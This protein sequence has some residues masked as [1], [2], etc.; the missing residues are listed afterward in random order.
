LGERLARGGQL[1]RTKM[2]RA[3]GQV[4]TSKGR[5][6]FKLRWGARPRGVARG[7]RRGGPN[8]KAQSK[9]LVYDRNKPKAG[10]GGHQ[11]RQRKKLVGATA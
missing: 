1:E 10:G 9:R 7:T 2:E 3:K 5:V 4:N 6:A 8:T 11:A